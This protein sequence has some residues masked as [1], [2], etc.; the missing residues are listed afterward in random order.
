MGHGLSPY[1]L[2]FRILPMFQA[3]SQVRWWHYM[4]G[5]LTLLANWVCTPIA[6]LLT[7]TAVRLALDTILYMIRSVWVR[8]CVCECVCAC[9]TVCECMCECVC[10]CE[11]VCL[12]VWVCV[13]E[14]HCVCECVCACECVC[15]CVWVHVWMCVCVWVRVS[16]CVSACVNVCVR[17]SACVTVCECVWESITVC[18][19][20]WVCETVCVCECESVSVCEC[21][22]VCVCVCVSLFCLLLC[23]FTP[24]CPLYHSSLTPIL[25]VSH[26]LLKLRRLLFPRKCLRVPK[27]I[28]SRDVSRSD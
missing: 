6:T 15:H 18:V 20:V 26:G 10:A 27:S 9:V 17:V 19:N 7:Q 21:E 4:E 25:H 1:T 3:K 22:G 28:S 16:L 12:C 23:S 14:Y 2:D 11:C 24:S 5:T 13:R 8:V